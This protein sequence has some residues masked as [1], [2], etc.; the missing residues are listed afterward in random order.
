MYRDKVAWSSVLAWFVLAVA[1]QAPTLHAADQ[2]DAEDIPEVKKVDDQ[3]DAI[4][5]ARRVDLPL[6][7]KADK[8]VIEEAKHA[9]GR[10]ATLSKREQI[11]ELT[12]A[13]KPRAVSPSGGRTAATLRFYRGDKLLRK[14]WVFEGGEWG[15]DRPGTSWTTGR[16][17]DLWKAIEKRLQ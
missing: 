11:R 2:P 13:L 4:R 17:K 14:V 6:L 1:A 3:S 12:R 8:V 9:G 16:D 15:F 7:A 10:R 5:E